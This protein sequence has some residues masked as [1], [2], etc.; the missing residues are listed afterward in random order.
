MAES[1][2]EQHLLQKLWNRVGRGPD[3]TLFLVVFLKN[4]KS[5]TLNIT[6]MHLTK[7]N[8]SITKSYF[9]SRNI[10]SES[11]KEHFKL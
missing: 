1:E 6:W 8:F 4:L 9:Y 11:L 10:N 7:G 3:S 2:Y 5:M